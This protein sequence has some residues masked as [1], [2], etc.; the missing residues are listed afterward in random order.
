MWLGLSWLFFFL[1]FVFFTASDRKRL[2]GFT[3]SST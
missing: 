1:R 2:I 3:S